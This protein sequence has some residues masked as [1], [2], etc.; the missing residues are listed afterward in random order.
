MK[1]ENTGKIIIKNNKFVG[2]TQQEH[3]RRATLLT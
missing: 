3:P 1:V 2:S